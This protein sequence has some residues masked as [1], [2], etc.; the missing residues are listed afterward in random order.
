MQ[1]QLKE[2]PWQLKQQEEVLPLIREPNWETQG[3]VPCAPIG[4]HRGPSPVHL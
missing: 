1:M 4:K 2:K 3:T